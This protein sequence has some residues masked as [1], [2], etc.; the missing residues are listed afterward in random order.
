MGADGHAASIFPGPDYDAALNGPKARKAI[1]VRPEPLPEAMPVQRV[2]LTK[3]ALVSARVVT[4][5][6]TGKDKQK[7]LKKALKDGAASTV[8]MGRLLADLE[9]DIDIHWCA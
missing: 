7:V 8:P 9:M 2:T 6:L 5:M 1:G 3:A 4:L